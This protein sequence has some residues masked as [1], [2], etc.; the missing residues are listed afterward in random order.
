MTATSSSQRLVREVLGA[1]R[2]SVGPE[3]LQIVFVS[4]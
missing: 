3:D 2:S 4:K 1:L